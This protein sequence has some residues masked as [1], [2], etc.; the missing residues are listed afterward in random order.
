MITDDGTNADPIA[1]LSNPTLREFN[2]EVA[3][4]FAGLKREVMRL[5]FAAG[6]YFRPIEGYVITK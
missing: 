4:A 5:R 1:R 3:A 6:G 2:P